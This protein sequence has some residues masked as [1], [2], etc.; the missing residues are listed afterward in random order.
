MIKKGTEIVLYSSLG[1]VGV[2][3]YLSLSRSLAASTILIMSL[4]YVFSKVLRLSSTRFSFEIILPFLALIF[5][6]RGFVGQPQVKLIFYVFLLLM[7]LTALRNLSIKKMDI[8][9]FASPIWRDGVVALFALTTPLALSSRITPNSQ[10]SWM[11]GGDGNN[12]FVH[13]RFLQSSNRQSLSGLVANTS[14]STIAADLFGFRFNEDPRQAMTN[15]LITLLNFQ[16]ICAFVLILLISGFLLAKKVKFTARLAVILSLVFSGNL[17]GYAQYNGFLS[18]LPTVLL[19][20]TLWMVQ[21][22]QMKYSNNYKV[23][24]YISMFLLTLYVWALLI[25]IVIVQFLYSFVRNPNKLF[26]RPQ[27]YMFLLGSLLYLFL[28]SLVIKT[29]DTNGWLTVVR[30]GLWPYPLIGQIVLVLTLL[31]TASY[32]SRN[33]NL[34]LL[35]QTLIVLLTCQMLFMTY[36]KPTFWGPWSSYYPQK[37]LSVFFL[38]ISI[39][40]LIQL[41]SSMNSLIPQLVMVFLLFTNFSLQTPNVLLNKTDLV[42]NPHKITQLEMD[43]AAAL[44]LILERI[45]KKESFAF[46]N[47][48]SWPAESS[49]NAWAGLAWEKYP[50]N[51]S[52]PIDDG[53]YSSNSSGPL[54]QRAYHNGDQSDST[55]LCRLIES[56][57]ENSVIYTQVVIETSNAVTDCKLS[58][59]IKIRFE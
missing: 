2:I 1:L 15:D 8:R 12:W 38:A 41:I 46:W 55:N 37:L 36:E 21:V 19:M 50:G 42:L 35:I 6:A 7:L 27:V 45:D 3:A 49:A 40:L 20:I 44:S 48:F 54:G 28:G 24:I 39:W 26:Y 53:V 18:V 47:K 59:K 34:N 52:M 11:M 9:N 16:L 56:L 10:F 31:F 22:N 14:G 32:L 30:G 57:P 17:L 33:L 29:F 23:T 5:V 13:L 25:P 58:K 51:W 43:T 4:V